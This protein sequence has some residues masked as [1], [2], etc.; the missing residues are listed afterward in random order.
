MR[1]YLV[2][3][4]ARMAG[5]TVR[6]LHHY[7]AIGLLMPA[8]R[9]PAGYRLYGDADLLR[10]QQ[11]LIEREL[12]LSLEEIRR[13]L[14][15]PS[16]D[17]RAA[18]PRQRRQLEQRLSATSRMIRAIDTAIAAL[19]GKHAGDIMGMS[20]I[21]DGFDPSR[22]DAEAQTRWGRTAAYKVSS[23]RMKGYSVGD[24]QRTKAEQDAIYR[25]AAATMSKGASPE[26]EVAMAI[27][28]RH[29]LIIDRWFYPCSHAVH[30]GLADMYEADVRFSESI[31]K[32]G[33]GLTTFLSAAIRANGRQAAAACP[34]TPIP[35]EQ[36]F[37]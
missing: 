23:E 32:H 37:I 20:D 35:D 36:A 18:L 19:D 2:T 34:T 4:V 9:T 17:H 31:D 7:E 24:W 27:A 3:D 6:T 10:L 21:F 5:V 12:G 11:I 25:D 8:D 30:G 28:E 16:F 22:H 29:R 1:T 13:L 15:E 33:A 26:G 14:D